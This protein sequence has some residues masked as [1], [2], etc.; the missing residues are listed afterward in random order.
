MKEKSE[1]S[2]EAHIKA[3]HQRCPDLQRHRGVLGSGK[4]P[5]VGGRAA[6][7]E[8]LDEEEVG[9]SP[10]EAEERVVFSGGRNRRRRADSLRRRQPL[11]HEAHEP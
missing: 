5:R 9:N 10:E 6:E 2:T 7:E 11:H 8:V 4:N 1:D 3:N